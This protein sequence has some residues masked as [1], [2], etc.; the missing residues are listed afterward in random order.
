MPRTVRAG[1]RELFISCRKKLGLTQKEL[2]DLFGLSSV[3]IRNIESGRE[4]TSHCFRFAKFFEVPVTDL[5]PELKNVDVPE[6]PI[7][8]T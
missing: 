4:N 2:G 8:Y 6:R 3:T 5:F 1:R 7:I